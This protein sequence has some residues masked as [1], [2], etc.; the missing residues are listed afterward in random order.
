MSDRVAPACQCKHCGS[1]FYVGGCERTA[2]RMAFFA[3]MCED[4]CMQLRALCEPCAAIARVWAVNTARATFDDRCGYCGG[5]V[6]CAD[7][8]IPAVVPL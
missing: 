4:S 6:L 5:A 8:I 3:H 7:D 2:T 1:H